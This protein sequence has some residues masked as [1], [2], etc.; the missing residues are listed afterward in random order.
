MIKKEHPNHGKIWRNLKCRLKASLKRLHIIPYDSNSIMLWKR[1]NY[2]D[3]KCPAP[4][5]DQEERRWVGENTGN[6]QHREITLY[7]WS[8]SSAFV[9]TH[10]T[11]DI[12]KSESS[13]KYGLQLTITCKYWF[14]KACFHRCGRGCDTNTL[15]SYP[16]DSGP[17]VSGP[18][19]E[20]VV[21]CA[22]GKL[23]SSACG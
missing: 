3:N 11:I 8:M 13:W 2:G 20:T 17:G 6:F 5:R 9:K 18:L 21:H 1:Q 19:L 7:E 23:C 15:Y 16:C 10:R 4:V 12:T 14:I 22:V